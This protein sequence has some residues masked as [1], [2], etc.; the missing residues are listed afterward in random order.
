MLGDGGD[1]L[2][3]IRVVD[4]REKKRVSIV[5]VFVGQNGVFGTASVPWT[6][7]GVGK[8]IMANPSIQ[9]AFT[10]TEHDAVTIGVQPRGGCNGH[11]VAGGQWHP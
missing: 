9:C 4:L 5:R 6:P 3:R 1:E 7:V 10:S 8:V 11:E 2:S